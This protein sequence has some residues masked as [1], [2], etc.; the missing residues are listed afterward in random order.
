MRKAISLLV[1]LIAACTPRGGP[2]P[3]REGAPRVVSLHDVTTEMVVT[4]GATDRLVGVGEL[5]DPPPEVRAAVTGVPRVGGIESLLAARPDV[6]LGL[7]VIAEQDPDLV[8]R[9]RG[10]GIDVLLADP[11]TLSDTYSLT[12]A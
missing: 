12:R 9:A 1:L 3:A 2:T 6:I 4:L 5:V 7:G 10:A 8:A 11:E